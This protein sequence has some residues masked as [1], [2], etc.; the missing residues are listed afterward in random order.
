MCYH[1]SLHVN[2]SSPLFQNIYTFFNSKWFFDYV[3]NSYVVKPVF[4]WGHSVSYKILDRG[5]IEF[6]GPLGVSR[7]IKRLSLFVSSLQSGY[8]YHY[9]FTIFIFA[10]LFL[11]F[12]SI[13]STS[14]EAGYVLLSHS[15]DLIL[16]IPFLLIFFFSSTSEKLKN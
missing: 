12:F 9:A 5:L 14:E 15:L 4:I 8:V 1:Y 10:T 3:Y 2:L 11:S 6:F 7:L 16:I 13:F